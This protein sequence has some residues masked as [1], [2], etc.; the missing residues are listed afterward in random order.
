MKSWLKNFPPFWTLVSTHPWLLFPVAI[1]TG[2]LIGFLIRDVPIMG[3]DWMTMF[4]GNQATDV[5]YPP[6]T[7]LILWP[8]AELPPRLGLA[9]INGITIATVA[10][11]TYFQGLGNSKGWR[12]LAVFMALFSVQ[13]LVVLWT[14]HIDGL[15]L[16][17]IWSLP[18]TMPIVLMKSTFIGFV[19]FTRK[20]WFLTALLFGLVSLLIWPNWPAEL[21]ATMEFRN[22]HPA[23]VGWERTGFLP[24]ILGI[25]LFLKSKRGDIF[26]NLAVGAMVYPF[27]MPYHHLVLLPALG[28]LK[29]RR[30]LFAWL[31]AWLIIVPVGIGT[32]YFV[33][34]LFPFLIWWFRRS[35]K[36]GEG[37]WLEFFQT[38]LSSA[39]R[40]LTKTRSPA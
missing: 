9:F 21:L 23:S 16:L 39:K 11:T 17:G 15:A 20:E 18:W 12:W 3:Y 40:F 36:E 22:T 38:K 26:Q 24:V 35:K 32:G 8:L 29:G 19:V 33:Y 37:T 10:L 14:G 13:T 1:V 5:Y 2:L 28:E 4:A 27:I 6:W 7:S 30:L 31:A 25:F 34:F